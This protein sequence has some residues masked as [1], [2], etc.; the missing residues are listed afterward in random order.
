MK[1]ASA[2]QGKPLHQQAMASKEDEGPNITSHKPKT[3]TAKTLILLSSRMLLLV[4]GHIDAHDAIH[5]LATRT[6]E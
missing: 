5:S 1:S 3:R 6:D 2:T 4:L